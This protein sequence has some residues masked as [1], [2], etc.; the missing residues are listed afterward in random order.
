[1]DNILSLKPPS[2][3]STLPKARHKPAPAPTNTN[4]VADNLSTETIIKMTTKQGY[5]KNIL[6]LL[7][8]DVLRKVGAFIKRDALKSIPHTVECVDGKIQ[9]IMPQN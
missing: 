6:G 7:D 4:N 3:P 2:K 8:T 5:K 9:G 1:M